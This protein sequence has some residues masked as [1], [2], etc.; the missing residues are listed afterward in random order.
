M[1]VYWQTTVVTGIGASARPTSTGSV[2]SPDGLLLSVAEHVD[3][4]EPI[5]KVCH[6]IIG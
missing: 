2:E 4:I 6:C 3:V 5:N 1:F